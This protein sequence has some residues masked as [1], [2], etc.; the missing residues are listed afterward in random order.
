MEVMRESAH[1]FT[2]PRVLFTPTHL[3]TSKLQHSHQKSIRKCVC[4]YVSASRYVHALFVWE[5]WLFACHGQDM[6]KSL[7][8]AALEAAIPTPRCRTS[9]WASSTFGPDSTE[10]EALLC[11][12]DYHVRPSPP[13]CCRTAV[14][15][16][17]PTCLPDLQATH[18]LKQPH[19]LVLITCTLPCITR[20]AAHNH[21]Q[22]TCVH[23]FAGWQL[24]LKRC[25]ESSLPYPAGASSR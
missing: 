24:S 20:L 22:S 2:I 7:L 23:V 6:L 17:A 1:G 12:A 14:L 9:A 25:L 8:H 18:N 4:I 5:C 21:T 10:P 16:K 11:S 13:A 19:A 15:L 3:L